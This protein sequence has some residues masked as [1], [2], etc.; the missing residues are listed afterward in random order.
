MHRDPPLKIG[1]PALV[2]NLDRPAL[3]FLLGEQIHVARIVGEQALRLG[4]LADGGED[5][6]VLLDGRM[7]GNHGA[8]AF[9]RFDDLVHVGH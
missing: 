3:R 8:K 2:F 4:V 7:S 9:R 1:E 6:L 5:G